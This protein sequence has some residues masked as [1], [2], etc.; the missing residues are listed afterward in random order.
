MNT[1][2]IFPYNMHIHDTLQSNQLYTYTLHSVSYGEIM[3][4]SRFQG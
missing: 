4:K 3:D 1:D 2:L